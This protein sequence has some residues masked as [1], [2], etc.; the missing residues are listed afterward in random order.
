MFLSLLLIF[1]SKTKQNKTK[2]KP[3]SFI[4]VF[5]EEQKKVIVRYAPRSPGLPAKLGKL[6]GLRV[7]YP[8]LT[9]FGGQLGKGTIIAG[10][11]I[12][13]S[14]SLCTEHVCTLSHL[15]FTSTP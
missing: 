14:L 7:P 3:A 13:E 15:P 9:P 1:L 8:R 12:T 11:T 5:T 10:D 4:E 6:A 2:Q